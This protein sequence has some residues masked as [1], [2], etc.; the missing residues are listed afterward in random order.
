VALGL[1][2]I[3]NKTI[4]IEVHKMKKHTIESLENRT[5]LAGFYDSVEQAELEVQGELFAAAIDMTCAL[6]N[7]AAT[8]V[9]SAYNALPVW[10]D[11][12]SAG[13]DKAEEL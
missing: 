2:L 8:S 3:K 11:T 7:W 13:V 1:I 5:L 6:Y 12:Q 9:V 4:L 10:G